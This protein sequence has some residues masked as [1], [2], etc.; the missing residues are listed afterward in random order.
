MN[1]FANRRVVLLMGMLTASML[2]SVSLAQNYDLK[3]GAIT[4]N[5]RLQWAETIAIDKSDNVYVSNMV[6]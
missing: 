4:R 1:L 3:M 6:D 2:A 5:S